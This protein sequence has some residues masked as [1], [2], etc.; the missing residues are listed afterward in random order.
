MSTSLQSC[1]PLNVSFG[2][3]LYS[4]TD[5]LLGYSSQCF[6][7]CLASYYFSSSCKKIQYEKKNSEADISGATV[8]Y[9]QNV[10]TEMVISG[11]DI[12]STGRVVAFVVMKAFLVTV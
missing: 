5:F 11:C 4:C 10:L 7:H 9:A 2:Y 12:G 6:T 3:W 8:D 1:L